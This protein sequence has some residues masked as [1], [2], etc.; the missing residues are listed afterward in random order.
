[1]NNHHDNTIS[2][3][4]CPL[5]FRAMVE[6]AAEVLLNSPHCELSQGFAE[7]LAEEILLVVAKLEH[8]DNQ[9]G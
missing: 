9:T 8:S 2:P 4:T 3:Q 6:A 7:D 5:I 1:M